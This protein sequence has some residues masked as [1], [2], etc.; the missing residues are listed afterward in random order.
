MLVISSV[1]VWN[2][3]LCGRQVMNSVNYIS[4]VLGHYPDIV[5]LRVQPATMDDL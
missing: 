4:E 1:T 3:R 5:F 2:F